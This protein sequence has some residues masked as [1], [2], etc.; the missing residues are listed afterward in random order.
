MTGQVYFCCSNQSYANQYY[1]F[2]V[3]QSPDLNSGLIYST[4]N[5]YLRVAQIPCSV[6]L[7][8]PQK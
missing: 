6:F 1:A 4:K 3:A 2:T 7:I 8:S 5:L